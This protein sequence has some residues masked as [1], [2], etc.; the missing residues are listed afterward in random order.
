VSEAYGIP[1]EWV[2]VNQPDFEKEDATEE[3]RLILSAYEEY[4]KLFED[5]ERVVQN[6]DGIKRL[7][8]ALKKFPMLSQIT[9]QDIKNTK[10]SGDEGPNYAEI[11][12]NSCL[13]KKCIRPWRWNGTTE[14]SMF[15]SPPTH[16]ISGLFTAL[17]DTDIR[18]TRFNIKLSAPAD[19]RKLQFSPQVLNAMTKTLSQAK[20]LHLNIDEWARGGSWVENKDRSREELAGLGALSRAFFS[21]SEVKELSLSMGNYPG[22]RQIPMISL[23]DVLVLPLCKPHLSVIIFKQ[24]PMMLG[25]MHTLVNS[26]K[27]TLKSFLS[28]SLYLLDSNWVE[29]IEV[30]RGLQNLEELEFTCP[31]GGETGLNY[32]SIWLTHMIEEYVLRQRA[33]NPL[34]DWKG[35]DDI[36]VRSSAQ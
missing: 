5:Q 36:I 24:I 11:L 17:A 13:R 30:L 35:R 31:K 7:V 23:D 21:S 14:T 6:G 29:G 1:D 33:E 2:K 34:I 3:Q 19:M 9:V 15:T 28:D 27:R 10:L 25:E 18:P 8:D 4:V 12:S 16:W 22:F 20:T 32:M 26:V